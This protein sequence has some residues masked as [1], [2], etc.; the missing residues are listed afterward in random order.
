MHF[1]DGKN[2]LPYIMGEKR[3]ELQRLLKEV[4]RMFDSTPTLMDQENKRIEGL[5]SNSLAEFEKVENNVSDNESNVVFA[6]GA[7]DD[8]LVGLSG[9][10]SYWDNLVLSAN[11]ESTIPVTTYVIKFGVEP[12]K[13]VYG[14]FVK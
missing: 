2:S 1:V 9:G 12:E 6:E 5:L 10:K 7:F 3:H 8:V 11:K 4:F 13:H 14:S